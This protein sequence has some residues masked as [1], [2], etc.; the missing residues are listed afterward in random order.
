MILELCQP[1]TRQ[2]V[3]IIYLFCNLTLRMSWRGRNKPGTGPRLSKITTVDWSSLSCFACWWLLGKSFESLL[4]HHH[5]VAFHLV[6]DVQHVFEGET[7]IHTKNMM[8]QNWEV[9]NISSSPVVVLG[10][11]NKNKI[12]KERKK[13]KEE[14]MTGRVRRRRFR[15]GGIDRVGVIAYHR[16]LVM[17]IPPTPWVDWW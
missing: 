11:W 14:E 3:Y 7:I 8:I 15:Q 16:C 5:G 13:T 2:E 12:K 1:L 9:R 17:V 4:Q 6:E 10:R